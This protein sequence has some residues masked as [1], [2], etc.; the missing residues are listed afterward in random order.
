MSAIPTTP[1]W[2]PARAGTTV[3]RRSPG[4]GRVREELE[5]GD[6]IAALTPTTLSMRGAQ[7]RGNLDG[8]EHM[9]ANR[10]C[11]G[12]GIATLRSQ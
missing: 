8:V 5:N 4:M 12:D 10:R 9:S 1:S 6:E 7:R 11:Y 2:V 3:A